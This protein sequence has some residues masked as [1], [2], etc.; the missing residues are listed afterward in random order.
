MVDPTNN[1]AHTTMG[2][3]K[4]TR[5]GCHLLRGSAGAR[6][7][8]EAL[9]RRAQFDDV[10]GQVVRSALEP[11]PA[12]TPVKSG[13]KKTNLTLKQE[14]GKANKALIMIYRLNLARLLMRSKSRF[15][16]RVRRG[17]SHG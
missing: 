14:G 1:D 11:A 7:V 4:G 16:I 17:V 10:I 15:V 5:Q 13:T 3:L 9:Q 12:P 8:N 2:I 6:N